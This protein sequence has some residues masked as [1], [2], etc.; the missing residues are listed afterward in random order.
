M[1]NFYTITDSILETG[2]KGNEL[3]VFAIIHSM[4]QSNKGFFC[5]SRTYLSK[6]TNCNSLRTIDN[7]L[8][9]LINK[10]LIAK[11]IITKENGE[12][13]LT[14]KSCLNKDFDFA[15]FTDYV[16][17]DIS[18]VSRDLYFK[19]PLQRINDNLFLITIK[20]MKDKSL[21]DKWTMLIKR[22]FNYWNMQN[23][24]DFVCNFKII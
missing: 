14:F 7:S 5:C 9:Q 12:R 19:E 17:Q 18:S 24:T 23:K 10:N 2:L 1:H 4:T 21:L 3:L 8:K 6:M 22:Q 13:V 16:L 20:G 15:K 11:E